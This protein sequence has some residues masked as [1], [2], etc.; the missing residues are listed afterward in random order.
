MDDMFDRIKE[1]TP[2]VKYCFFTPIVFAILYIIAAF[3]VAYGYY[4]LVRTLTLVFM[5]LFLIMF[6]STRD[7]HIASFPA[8]S[9]IVL[10]ILFN[11]ISPIPFG[12]T[13]WKIID[14][15]SA[16]A[17]VIMSICV[18]HKGNDDI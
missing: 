10:I 16:T 3:D 9:T 14:V 6:V 17:C 13:G 2:Q 15:I 18:Y 4:V 12:A 11:P 8:I 5:I 1:F 7:A